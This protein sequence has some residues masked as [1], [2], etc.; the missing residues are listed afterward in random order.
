[1]KKL[2]IAAVLTVSVATTAFT[3]DEKKIDSRIRE[4]F[5]SEYAEAGNVKWS[6]KPTYVRATFELNGKQS[7]V[8]YS[9]DG[10]TIG[11]SQKITLDKLPVH[12]KRTFAKRYADYT[13]KEAIKFDGKD[14]T[15]YFI[16][17][18]NDKQ[19]VILKVTDAGISTYKRTSKS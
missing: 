15:A 2:L 5:K 10:E 14:E 13:V 3:A 6:M 16:S 19:S 4:N 18:E 8:Y 11:T 7:D 9:L 17:A 1:M 12:A